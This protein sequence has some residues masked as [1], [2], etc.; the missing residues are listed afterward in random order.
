METFIKFIGPCYAINTM[1]NL[2]EPTAEQITRLSKLHKSISSDLT[3][4]IPASLV[5]LLNCTSQ[6][7]IT[8]PNN[9]LNKFCSIVDKGG[10]A[11]EIKVDEGKIM[12]AW[13]SAGAPE[14]WDGEFCNN[15]KPRG[16]LIRNAAGQFQKA[17]S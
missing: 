7:R 5:V 4:T 17:I 9:S 3:I 14:N 12:Q 6:T 13:L 2:T 11:L 10:S 8:V 1:L 16:N 15:P